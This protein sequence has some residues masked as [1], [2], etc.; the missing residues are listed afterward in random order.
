MVISECHTSGTEGEIVTMSL[1]CSDDDTWVLT[2]KL[3]LETFYFRLF[4]L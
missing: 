2:L 3:F 4:K 1:S